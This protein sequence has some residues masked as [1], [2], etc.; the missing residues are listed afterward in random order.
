MTSIDL[1]KA[2]KEYLDYV[3][4]VPREQRELHDPM[5]PNPED[6]KLSTRKWK[7]DMAK[8]HRSLHAEPV[9]A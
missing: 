1:I 7:Y 4:R 5:T 9:S 8:W 3:E 6:R 2:K